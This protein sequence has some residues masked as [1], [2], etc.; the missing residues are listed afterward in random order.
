[1]NFIIYSFIAAI[2]GILLLQFVWISKQ[3]K[4][5][6]YETD[7]TVDEHHEKTNNIIQ[8]TEQLNSKIKANKENN[9]EPKN[10]GNKLAVDM[11]VSK[12]LNNNLNHRRFSQEKN[13]PSIEGVKL[14]MEFFDSYDYPELADYNLKTKFNKN[15][16]TA[17]VR[18]PYWIYLYW[19][20]NQLFEVDGQ[21]IL[22]VLDITAKNYPH[23]PPNSASIT[24]VNLDA[25]NWYLKVPKANRRYTIELGIQKTTGKFELIARSNYFTTPRDKPSDKFDPEFM[26]IDGVFNY[27]YDTLEFNIGSSPLGQAGEKEIGPNISSYTIIEDW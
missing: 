27:S 6:T 11:E 3:D 9:I 21:T 7:E 24:E 13:T 12:E 1:M 16:I 19:E 22:K 10:I 20:V 26:T 15:R 18:D 4:E 5:S 14:S 8:K 25:Q 23:S 17:L 2:L